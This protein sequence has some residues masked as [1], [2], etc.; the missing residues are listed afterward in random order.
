MKHPQIC[1]LKKR[2]GFYGGFADIIP[3]SK[4]QTRT[5]NKFNK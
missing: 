4:G 3:N 1:T 2:C 5:S